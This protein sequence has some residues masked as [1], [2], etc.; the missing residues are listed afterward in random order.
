[1]II[2]I[3]LILVGLIGGIILYIFIGPT[4]PA[5]TNQII[6]EITSNKIPELITGTTG[7][8]KSNSINIWFE[9]RSNSPNARGTIL[10][11]SGFTSPSTF[12]HQNFIQSIVETG[13]QV[14][15]FDNR[16][17]G[18]SDWLKNWRRDSPYKIGDMVNDAVAVL[19]QN[20]IK[21]A[22]VVGYS[23]G[24]CIGLGL[25]IEYPER[26]LSLTSLSSTADINETQHPKFNWSPL[27]VIKLFIRSRII[28]TDKNYLKM[29]FKFYIHMNGNNSYPIELKLLGERGL[30]EL[31]NR[32]GFNPSARKQQNTAIRNSKSY[33]G[34]LGRIKIPT[35][36]AHGQNDPVLSFELAKRY[37]NELNNS[38]QIWIEKTGHVMTDYYIQK[39]L[40]DFIK[41]LETANV[42]K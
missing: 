32:R 23:M 38:K 27:P 13:Y 35:L 1:M 19:D 24:G 39:I 33:Y 29:L 41:L 9:N 3:I 34:R 40:P 12:W 7:Y 8:A 4:L 31:H 20:N 42:T 26:V 6:R 22:H 37:A 28:R 10:L 16:S 25:A 36:I 2:I 5:H 15:R 30:Y 21:K 14:I 17:V 18:L 11:I